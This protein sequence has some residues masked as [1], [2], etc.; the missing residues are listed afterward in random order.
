MSEK[1]P[2]PRRGAASGF[3]L[4]DH[5]FFYFSQILSRRTRALNIALRAYDLDYPRWRVLAVLHEHSGATMGQVA[6]LT[7][8][9]RTTLTHTLGLLEQEK[10]I[11]RQPRA[12]D[13]R[14]LEIGLS[15]AGR[16]LFAKILPLTLAET[17]KALAGFTP[18]Q[19]DELRIALRRIADNLKE[20]DHGL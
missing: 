7:S 1:T 9:D 10:L 5:L 13:R 14:N 16:R 15:P 12:S 11:S 2:A 18:P 6:E 17:E 8:V 3:H 20:R 19:V 4:E